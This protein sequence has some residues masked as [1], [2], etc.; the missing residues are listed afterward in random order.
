ML[1]EISND[2]VP[3]LLSMSVYFSVFALHL[4][5]L[6]IKEHIAQQGYSENKRLYDLQSGTSQQED[7]SLLVGETQRFIT[8]ITKRKE[9]PED[10]SDYV[11]SLGNKYT[12][13]NRG[14]IR[15]K[16]ALYSPFLNGTA[17]SY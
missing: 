9:A 3:V 4:T 17:L 15:W 12:M 10:D 14:G 1:F 11:Y 6:M 7:T 16:T 8:R 2:I 13:D 5:L